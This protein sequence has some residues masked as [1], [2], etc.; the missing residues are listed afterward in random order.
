MIRAAVFIAGCLFS[1]SIFAANEY[2]KDEHAVHL[3]DTEAQLISAMGE[4]TRKVSM[5][6]SR[7]DHLGDYYICELS[8]ES[9][10]IYVEKGRVAE[11]T[12]IPGS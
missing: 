8:K 5:E 11:I 6:N 9:V 10:R 1:G 12:V 2:G 4:P 7:G 3:R